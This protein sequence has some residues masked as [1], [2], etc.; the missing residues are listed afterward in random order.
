MLMIFMFDS[1]LRNKKQSREF[2]NILNK[3][4]KHIQFTIEDE[5]KGKCLNF[6]TLK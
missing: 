2:Q 6:W 4:D 5:N 1:R 3:K